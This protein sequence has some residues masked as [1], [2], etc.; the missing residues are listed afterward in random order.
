MR[1]AA[2]AKMATTTIAVTADS[3]RVSRQAKSKYQKGK[4]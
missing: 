4:I 1:R 2:A 3:E